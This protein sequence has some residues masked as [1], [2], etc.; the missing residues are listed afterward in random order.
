MKLARRIL[1]GMAGLIAIL[2]VIGLFLPASIEVERSISIDA[3]ATEVYAVVSDFRRFNDWSPWYELDPQASYSISEPA[4]GVGATFAWESEDPSVGSGSQ[5]IIE[6]EPNRLVR[7]NL[8]FGAQGM[9][10]ASYELQPLGEQST[11]I[12]WS[13]ETDFGYDLVG[14]YVGLM[15]DDWVG[16]DYEKGLARLKAI[17]EAAYTSKVQPVS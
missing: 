14:R 16:R 1:V 15:I 17:V 3:P 10:I 12:T 9:A 2:V 5:Q 6:L 11:R 13:M 8:D 7:V 4:S